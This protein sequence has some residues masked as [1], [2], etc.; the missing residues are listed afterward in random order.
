MPVIHI[1]MLCPPGTGLLNAP[2]FQ[3]VASD[4]A[5]LPGTWGAAA[6]DGLKPVKGDIVVE[7]QRMSGFSRAR[8]STRSC[9]A[10]ARRRS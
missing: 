6:V 2:L 3:G 10:S 9:A 5:C 4:K 1:H 7:K 8:R